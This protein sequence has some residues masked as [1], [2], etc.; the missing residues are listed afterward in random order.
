MD[1]KVKKPWLRLSI[2][3]F[4]SVTLSIL[5]LAGCGGPSIDDLKA[6]DYTPL[7][8][9]DWEISTPEE[10]GLGCASLLLPAHREAEPPG[11]QYHKRSRY[12]SS[13]VD[14]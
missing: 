6:V 1:K 7:T 14:K 8:R 4:A 9:D 11:C 10:E 3:F 5:I 2:L 12:H 13:F